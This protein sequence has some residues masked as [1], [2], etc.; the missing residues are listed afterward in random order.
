MNPCALPRVLT[1]SFFFF[2]IY[3]NLFI[4]CDLKKNCFCH[5]QICSNKCL[6]QGEDIFGKLFSL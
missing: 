3:E 4:Y 5:P 6:G 1:S 2:I